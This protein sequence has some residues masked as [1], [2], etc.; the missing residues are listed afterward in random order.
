M[1][2]FA[3]LLLVKITLL[4]L[5]IIGLNAAITATLPLTWGEPIIH[6]KYKAYQA[7]AEEINTLLIGTSRT[8][9]HLDPTLLDAL[10]GE[11][12]NIRAFNLGAPA[13]YY[14]KSDRLYRAILADKPPALDYALFEF[15]RIDVPRPRNL[16]TKGHIYWYDFSE[17]LFLLRHTWSLELPLRRKLTFSQRHVVSWLEK[18]ANLGL[19]VALLDYALNGVTGEPRWLGSRGD[20]FY[21]LD[22]ALADGAL[23]VRARRDEYLATPSE[24]DERRV[25]SQAAYEA[26]LASDAYSVA[27]LERY[28]ALIELSERKGVYLV[29]YLPPRLGSDYR[30]LV[31]VFEQL[32]PAHRFDL[33]PPSE[34][35][36]YYAQA[37]TFDVGHLNKEGARLFTQDVAAEWARRL[38]TTKERAGY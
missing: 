4:L 23:D 11:P 8:Y 25:E 12:F 22:D 30:E 5:L 6:A 15:G 36:L 26:G 7:Q 27:L 21:P 29:F 19:G 16:H 1:N 9:R 24:A 28:L 33:A 18:E 32:P 35:P 13:Y 38:A 3:A 31:P 10:V 37:Y 2:R 34:H 20:G 14:P 17:T